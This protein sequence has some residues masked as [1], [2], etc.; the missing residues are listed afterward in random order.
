[1][2]A[3]VRESIWERQ[4]PLSAGVAMGLLGFLLG[5]AMGG[6]GTPVDPFVAERPEE[7]RLANLLVWG[8]TLTIGFA[9][10]EP[11]GELVSAPQ[12]SPLLL[13]VLAFAPV[14][15]ADLL[16]SQFAIAISGDLRCAPGMPP[17]PSIFSF[18]PRAAILGTTVLL[19]L[20][21]WGRHLENHAR[22]ESDDMAFTPS[23]EAYSA[24]PGEWLHL[25]EAPFLRVRVQDVAL[26]RSAGNYSEIVAN[27]RVHLVRAT[28]S[29]LAHRFAPLGFVRVHRQTVVN[30]RQ[31][32]EIRR[33]P[34]GRPVVH[35]ACGT[36][37]PL[38]RRFRS[39]V[40]ALG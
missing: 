22:R 25:P 19:A 23:P 11:V 6:I 38:G 29:E 9:C 40:E 28:L 3:D 13:A 8:L 24:V 33:E 10:R 31:V 35:L 5:Y 18:L 2:A 36:P 1:M 39:A 20:L 17:L 37:I 34:S 4:I 21:A 16:A 12:R 15:V 32:R 14:T 27:G 7:A 26:I 30:A